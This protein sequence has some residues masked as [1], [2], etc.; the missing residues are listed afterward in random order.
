MA[1]A[2]GITP[3][4]SLL[5]RLLEPCFV[6]ISSRQPGN[7]SSQTAHP[8][9]RQA[10]PLG[11]RNPDEAVLSSRNPDELK[12]Q[13]Q[14]GRRRPGLAAVAVGAEAGVRARVPSPAGNAAWQGTLLA[15]LLETSGAPPGTQIPL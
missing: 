7:T 5:S 6:A 2:G 11:N 12:G 14:P 3:V 9:D 8:T 13:A 10:R 1:P 15:V 4:N